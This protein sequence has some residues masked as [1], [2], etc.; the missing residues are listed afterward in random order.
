MID[1]DDKDLVVT[2]LAE[3]IMNKGTELATES[4]PGCVLQLYVW[5]ENPEQA[6][7]YALVSIGI[8][9]LTTGFTSAMITFDSD[10][11]VAHRKGQPKFYGYVADTKR[12]EAK[13][14]RLA[15]LTRYIGTF[16]MTTG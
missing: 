13:E 1:E 14:T 11:D 16:P 9:A 5:I 15:L 12:S 8:S 4:L 7:A 2:S 10:V 3:M 6:G